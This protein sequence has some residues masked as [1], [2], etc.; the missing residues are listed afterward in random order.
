MLTKCSFV[1]SAIYFS[2]VM[3]M[4]F[5]TSVVFVELE[6]LPLKCDLTFFQSS[7]LSATS[8]TFNLTKYCVFVFLKRFRQ[9]FRWCL[10]FCQL[11]WV[12]SLLKMF[13]C[14][15]RSIIAFLNSFVIKRLLLCRKI[16]F[17]F[18]FE[19]SWF[20]NSRDKF[21]VIRKTRFKSAR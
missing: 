10:Y 11:K 14:F 6:P 2:S 1:I 19:S 5:S 13:F 4:S 15:D 12:L 8:L 18:S 16:F 20:Q 17:R 7:L 9:K 21:I 3:I